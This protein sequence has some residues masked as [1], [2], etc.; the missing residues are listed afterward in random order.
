MGGFLPLAHLGAPFC[1]STADFGDGLMPYLE[2]FDD[3]FLW[4]EVGGTWL[5]LSGW[6]GGWVNDH[7]G[8]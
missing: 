7:R 5:F 3:R 6:V 8:R 1:E 2:S 4:E